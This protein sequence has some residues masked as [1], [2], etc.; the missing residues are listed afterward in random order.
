MTA[1]EGFLHQAL[2]Y[3]SEAE[4]VDCALPFVADG[5]AAGEPVLVVA[6]GPNVDALRD[7]LGDGAGEATLLP[8]EEWYENPIRTRGKFGNW[9][10]ERRN[11]H[12]IRLIGEPPWPLGSAGAVREWARNEAVVNVEFDGLPVTFICPYD[13]RMLPDSIIEHAES[14]HPEIVSGGAAVKS[15][16][17]TQPGAYCRRLTEEGT[18]AGAPVDAALEFGFHELAD[19]RRL[20]EREAARAGVSD[21]RARRLVVAVNEVATNALIHGS[22]P[23]EVRTYR[24]D[25]DLVYEVR[26]SGDWTPDPLAGQL[27]PDFS[28]AGGWGMWVA[29]MMADA[30]EPRRSDSGTVVAVHASL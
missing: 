29:R 27:R 6:Q 23:Q 12:R 2:I 21:E 3:G 17:Y 30:V 20:A 26:D 19:V 16:A 28:H 11:G 25:G 7:A 8:V 22:E 9:V 24:A 15:E 10:R 14:T 1:A 18:G 5:V 13:T 4:F